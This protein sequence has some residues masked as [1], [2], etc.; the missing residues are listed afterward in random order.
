MLGNFC[1]ILL[2][3][4]YVSAGIAG[5]IAFFYFAEHP[6]TIISQWL[7]GVV[8]FGPIA[9]SALF[10]INRFFWLY[11]LRKSANWEYNPRPMRYWTCLAVYLAWIGFAV[12]LCPGCASETVGMG[13]GIFVGLPL[14]CA[15]GWLWA[16]WRE[17]IADAFA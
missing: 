6:D 12:V 7:L 15:W 8:F 1:R 10:Y 4:L 5:F 2:S 17:M 16:Y 11:I 3:F 9:I 14:I 13:V